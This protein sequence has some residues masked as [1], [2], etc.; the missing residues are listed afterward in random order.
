[1]DEELRRPLVPAVERLRRAGV[2]VELAYGVHRQRVPYCPLHGKYGIIDDRVVLD[3]SFNWYNTSVASHDMAAI[4]AN[5]NVA[6]AYSREFDETR[7][8]ML[9]PERKWS[10]TAMAC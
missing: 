5:E 1:M 9:F 6:R 8:S 2:P 7:A 3:G 4:V 10:S